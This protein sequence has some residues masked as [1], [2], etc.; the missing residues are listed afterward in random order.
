LPRFKAAKLS[1][2]PLAVCALFDPE[3]NE[4]TDFPCRPANLIL[5]LNQLVEALTGLE[6]ILT[7]PI[8]Y[9]SVALYSQNRQILIAALRYSIHL[10]TVTLVYCFFLVR[11]T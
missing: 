2:R 6:R 10:W 4:L 5:A 1:M 3:G 8:P 11:R 9:S 7:T